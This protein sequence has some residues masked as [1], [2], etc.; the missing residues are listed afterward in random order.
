[1][2]SLSVRQ[3]DA[4]MGVGLADRPIPAVPGVV[5]RFV[6]ARGA[7]FHVAQAGAGDP[8]VL[9]HGLPQHWYA[10]RKVIPELAGEYQLFCVDL[11]GCGWSEATRRGYGTEDLVRDI[12]AVMDA[13]GLNRVRLI[14]T[15]PA[16][17]SGSRFAFRH[18]SGSAGSWP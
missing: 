5:H 16:A 9:L 6:A 3:G 17:G 2:T 7:R 1:M 4:R 12:L 18:P 13:L 14:G 8:V 10:W 11:R 15:R